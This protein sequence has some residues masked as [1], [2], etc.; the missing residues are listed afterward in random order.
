MRQAIGLLVEGGVTEHP[1]A[2]HQRRRIRRAR[3]L[4]LHQRVHGVPGG[5]GL[6]RGVEVVQQVPSLLRG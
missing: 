2:L 1:I 3:H 4:G 5:K 6:G